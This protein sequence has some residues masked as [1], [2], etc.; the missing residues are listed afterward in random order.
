MQTITLVTG[1]AHKI[2]EYKRLLPADFPFE[3]RDLDLIEIQS[4]DSIEIIADKAQRAYDIIGGPVMVEDVSAGL[5]SLNGLPGPFIKFFNQQLGHDSLYKIAKDDKRTTVTCTIGYY[6]GS[7]LLLA[8]G[9]VKGAVVPLRGDGGF[10]FD[11][12]FVPKG[13]AKT[14]AQMTDAEKDALSHRA[15][16]VKDLLAQLLPKSD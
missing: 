14:Y 6:D 16:A 10:G 7:R 4:F 11:G 13:H 1:N 3:V 2:A 5:D 8:S 15:L 12:V 9:A